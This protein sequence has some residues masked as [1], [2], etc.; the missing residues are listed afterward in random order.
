MKFMKTIRG[1]K[2]NPCGKVA[3]ARE[4]VA[5]QAHF[6]TSNFKL[7]SLPVIRFLLSRQ[8]KD[9]ERCE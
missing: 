3:L 8:F 9:N 5:G 7:D 6:D 2:V 1:N 4:D